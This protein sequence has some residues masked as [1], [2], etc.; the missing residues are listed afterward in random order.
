MFRWFVALIFIAASVANGLS[1]LPDVDGHKHNSVP[2]VEAQ[3]D[4][5]ALVASDLA[6]RPARSLANRARHLLPVYL[7]PRPQPTCPSLA[8][9][10]VDRL[11]LLD[12]TPRPSERLIAPD[13]GP[14]G[15][16][17]A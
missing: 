16:P 4:E 17:L 9:C 13:I 15:P 7:A 1:S 14:R 5:P 6:V 3:S 12:E 11:F 8:P 10:L 2:T